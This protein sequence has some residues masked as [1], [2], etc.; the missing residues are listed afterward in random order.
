MATPRR[1]NIPVSTIGGEPGG[2][3][4]IVVQDKLAEAVDALPPQDGQT[5]IVVGMP[6]PGRDIFAGE[7][8]KG[9]KS[10]TPAAEPPAPKKEISMVISEQTTT[11]EV[12]TESAPPTE[13]IDSISLETASS[14]SLDAT[15]AVE[16]QQETTQDVK[17][18]IEKVT[19]PLGEAEA[20]ADRAAKELYPDADEK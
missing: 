10:E 13:S 7:H 6:E 15:S 4:P 17:T 14:S 18:D 8:A 12:Q 20:E 2:R 11:S 5:S 9:I 19:G 3:A 16:T 1:S